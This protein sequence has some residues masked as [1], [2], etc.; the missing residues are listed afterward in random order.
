MT[1]IDTCEMEL[2]CKIMGVQRRIKLNMF[3]YTHC[4][5]F[6]FMR[7]NVFKFSVLFTFQ[8]LKSLLK[9]QRTKYIFYSVLLTATLYC[10]VVV[11]RHCI[12]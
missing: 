5:G 4:S 10:S 2:H 8:T 11:M 6:R 12:P 9:Y 7:N 1:I 3:E